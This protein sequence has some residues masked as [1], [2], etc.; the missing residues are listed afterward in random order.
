MVPPVYVE[1]TVPIVTFTT[2]LAAVVPDREMEYPL[3]AD[4]H[5]CK[6]GPLL[7]VAV[8]LVELIAVVQ[9]GFCVWNEVSAS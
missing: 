4:G 6:N 5:D 1:V 9:V 3:E 7:D 2:V 8:R